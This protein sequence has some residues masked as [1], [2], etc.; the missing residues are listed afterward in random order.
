MRR[1][2]LLL[3]GLFL[4]LACGDEG[5]NPV[6]GDELD[7]TLESAHYL[8]RWSAADAGVDT[9]WQERWHV[10][11]TDRLGL[12]PGWK[13]E[14]RKYRDLAHIQRVTGHPGRG[15]AEPEKHLFHTVNR[16]DNHEATH[17]VWV[18]LVGRTPSFFNEG[19]AVAHH[20]DPIRGSFDR[21]IWNGRDIHEVAA[22]H[23]ARGDVPA[24]DA[25]LDT[26]DFWDHD[27]DVTYPVAGSFVRFLLDEHG[28]DTFK[29]FAAGLD[30]GADPPSRVRARF[31]E[32]YGRELDERWSAWKRFV[33]G[34]APAR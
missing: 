5:T 12:R 33:T 1:A 20:G 15:V 10:W 25:L 18:E 9:V 27:Q 14:Y 4:A 6:P 7:V 2:T 26:D 19:I 8:Y 24:L 16:L 22:E 34:G 23:V 21:A 32:R 17:V 11:V 30:G 29:A 28:V 3:P 31:R 13:I